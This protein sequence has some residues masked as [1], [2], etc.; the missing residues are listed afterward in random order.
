M[1]DFEPRMNA[2][3]PMVIEQTNRGERAFDQRPVGVRAVR[4][5][6]LDAHRHRILV[7][8]RDSGI[9]MDKETL[10]RAFDPF[11]RADISDYTAK[12]MGLTIAQRLAERL[13]WSLRLESKLGE[14]TRATLQF[15]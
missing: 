3:V 13:G 8:V 4:T 6:A 7:A 10:A 12:G 15:A 2:L 11:W 1:N 9:G 5:E 14:G